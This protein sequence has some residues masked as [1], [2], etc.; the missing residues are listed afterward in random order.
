[1]N[2]LTSSPPARVVEVVDNNRDRREYMKAYH[3][4]YMKAYRAKNR[5]KLLEWQKAY[6]PSQISNPY[7][8]RTISAKTR[9]SRA[10][11]S[12]RNTFNFA[13]TQA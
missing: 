6:A 13:Y 10:S 2:L 11:Q 8:G 7:G 3:R 5:G 1:M 12:C 4:D 9:K